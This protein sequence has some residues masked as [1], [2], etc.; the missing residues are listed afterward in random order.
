MAQYF[1]REVDEWIVKFKDSNDP[2]EKEFIF[3]RK[4]MPAFLK[5]IDN[6]LQ[7]YKFYKIDDRDLLRCECLS[8][9]YE[10]LPKFDPNKGAKGFSYFNVVVRN[11]FTNRAR[12]KQKKLKQQSESTSIDNDIVKNDPSVVLQ[13]HETAHMQR[14]FW[15]ELI[16]DMGKWSH[17]LKK[18]H[19]KAV[20]NAIIFLFQHPDLVSI[21]NK[22]AVH[23]YIKEITGLTAKQVHHNINKLKDLY[24]EFREDFQTSESR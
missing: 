10:V 22:K 16:L 17:L 24:L 11:F 9:C 2:K 20:L 5:L 23:L 12:D 14:E 21:F 3:H 4:I 1:D 13:S 19:E 6:Q 15:R 18:D 8:H 7:I